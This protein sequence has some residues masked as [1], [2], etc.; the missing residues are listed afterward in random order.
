M[1]RLVPVR[2]GIYNLYRTVLLVENAVNYTRVHY[3]WSSTNRIM[4]YMDRDNS[5]SGRGGDRQRQYVR[6]TG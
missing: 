2:R 6:V 3:V 1:A 4:I 5:T